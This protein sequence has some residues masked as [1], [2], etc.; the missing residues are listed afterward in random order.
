M[1]CEF[2]FEN[3]LQWLA[4]KVYTL[5]QDNIVLVH[6]GITLINN[7]NIRISSLCIKL[8][9]LFDKRVARNFQ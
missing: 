6:S 5:R 2:H 3:G 4:N 9:K 8:S 7:K 1:L